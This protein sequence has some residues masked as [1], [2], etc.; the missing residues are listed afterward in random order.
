MIYFKLYFNTKEFKVYFHMNFRIALSS[1][2]QNVI[3]IL[4]QMRWNL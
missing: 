2:V 1:L 3:R 4:M